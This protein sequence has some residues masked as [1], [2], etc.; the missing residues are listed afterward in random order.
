MPRTRAAKIRTLRPD[1]SIPVG[2][3]K[4]YTDGRGYVRLRWL[5]DVQTYVE[6]YEHRIVMGRPLGEVH[7][8]NGVKDD[9]RPENLVVLSKREHAELHEEL[10]KAADPDRGARRARD[11]GLEREARTTRQRLRVEAMA[12]D[13][14]DGMSTIDISAKY[15]VHSSNVSRALRAA[16]VRMRPAAV[17]GHGLRRSQQVVKARAHMRC[18][19]CGALTAWT[20]GQVHHRLPRG[21]G[22]ST[23]SDIHSPANLLLLCLDCHTWVESNRTASYDAGWLVHRGTDPAQ[24]PVE[25]HT[26]R[27]ILTTNGDYQE[28]A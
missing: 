15:G 25:L 23:A 24:V 2:D 8:I 18:E 3:P 1:E 28:T 27:V 14:R 5:V 20:G 22:G 19:R 13:Y 4:R 9:N 26:G 17:A 12:A 7:H 16:G 11:R 10:A 21:M 6:E